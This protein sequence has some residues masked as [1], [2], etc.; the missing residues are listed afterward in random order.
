MYWVHGMRKVF[1]RIYPVILLTKPFRFIREGCSLTIRPDT[2]QAVDVDRK[3]FSRIKDL[4]AVADMIGAAGNPLAV[5]DDKASDGLL[6]GLCGVPVQQGNGAGET[7]GH[8][9]VVAIRGE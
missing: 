1:Y 5:G 4:V 7:L 3:R 2:A 9:K 8:E 6:H